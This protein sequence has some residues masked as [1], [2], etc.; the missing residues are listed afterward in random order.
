MIFR[1]VSSY[2]RQQAFKVQNCNPLYRLSIASIGYSIGCTLQCRYKIGAVGYSGDSQQAQ[3]V[4]YSGDHN[5]RRL[6]ATVGIHNRRCK[7][8][9]GFVEV[10]QNNCNLSFEKIIAV[11]Y[12]G[13]LKKPLQATEGILNPCCSLQQG[14]FKK[15]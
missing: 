6:Q 5:R 15:F 1:I 14:I 12:S 8:Q 10:L 4:G 13:D 9:H 11:G 7:L 2:P 3:T